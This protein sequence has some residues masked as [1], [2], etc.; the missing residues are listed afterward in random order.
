MRSVNNLFVYYFV[1]ESEIGMNF[2]I[3]DYCEFYKNLL[4]EEI[5]L[6]DNP[7]VLHYGKCSVIGYAMRK[8]N[9]AFVLGS[10]SIPKIPR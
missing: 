7:A 9:G 3:P 4:V 5:V 2:S 6:C 10:L 1:V 8:D